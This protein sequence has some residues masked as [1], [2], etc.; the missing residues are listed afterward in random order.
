MT[1]HR[2]HEPPLF[3]ADLPA[4]GVSGQRQRVRM[5]ARVEEARRLVDQQDSGRAGRCKGR[6]G[7]RVAGHVVV[8]THDR[9]PA[10]RRGQVGRF[11]EQDSHADRLEVPR[12]AAT[13]GIVVV[14]AQDRIAP[15]GRTE[16]AEDCREIGE[17]TSRRAHE[18]AAVQQDIGLDGRQQTRRLHK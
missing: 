1:L 6:V 4:V 3:S 14:I 16:V 8:E 10:K 15:A 2:V 5:V 7:V 9:E 12:H 11:V 13:A 18:I 17:V